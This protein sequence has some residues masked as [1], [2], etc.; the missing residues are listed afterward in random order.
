MAEVGCHWR[1]DQ[2][3]VGAVRGDLGTHAG[4]DKLVQ[5][6]SGHSIIPK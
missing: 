3:W 4:E 2:V 5:F 6:S 1:T